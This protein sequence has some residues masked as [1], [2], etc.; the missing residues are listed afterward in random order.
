MSRRVIFLCSI[1]ELMQTLKTFSKFLFLFLLSSN[2]FFCSRSS[3][4]LHRGVRLPHGHAL[5]RRSHG[6]PRPI[7]HA[8]AQPI[9]RPDARPHARSRP[10]GLPIRWPHRQRRPVR[11]PQRQPHLFRQGWTRPTAQRQP[12]WQPQ[13]LR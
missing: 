5:P 1:V 12:L 6:W 7:R 13:P 3:S 2:D 8:H 4:R 11:L 9:Q 10:N